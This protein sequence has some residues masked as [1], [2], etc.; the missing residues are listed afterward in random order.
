MTATTVTTYAPPLTGAKAPTRPGLARLTLV[1]MRKTVD[2]RAGKWL[3]GI[4]VLLSVSLVTIGV[5]VGGR[6]DRTLT[7]L[8]LFTVLPMAVILPV[9]GILLVTSEWSQRTALTTFTLVPQ[10]PRIAAAKLL[11]GA[12]FSVLALLTC[13]IVSALGN[14]VCI[15]LDRGSGGWHLAA[16]DV[17]QSLLAVVLAVVMGV[18]FGMLFLNSPLAIVLYFLLPIVISAVNGIVTA[19]HGVMAWLDYNQTSSPLLGDRL[20]AQKWAQLATSCVLW[21]LLPLAVGLVRLIRSE[22]K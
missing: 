11:A 3:V 13:L 14:L 15:V 8:F 10:R 7:N 4:V 21:I 2:T 17:G 18:A 1:E 22:V 19:L 12:T 5:I 6:A 9:L 16:A 20:D